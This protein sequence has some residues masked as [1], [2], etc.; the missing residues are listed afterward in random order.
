MDVYISYVVSMNFIQLK[1]LCY[2][3]A[4]EQQD[5]WIDYDNGDVWKCTEP[6]VKN[7]KTVVESLDGNVMETNY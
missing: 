7:G 4:M 2:T 6:R 3:I 5:I 1:Q